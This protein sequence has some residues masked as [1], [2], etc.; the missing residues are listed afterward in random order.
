M[1]RKKVTFVSLGLSKIPKFVCIVDS[2]GPDF[3]YEHMQVMYTNTEVWHGANQASQHA[4]WPWVK[5]KDFL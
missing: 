2:S 1:Q 4:D 3:Q 5:G